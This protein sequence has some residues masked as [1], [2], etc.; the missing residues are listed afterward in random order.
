[1]YGDVV[2]N[3]HV[4]CM[5]GWHVPSTFRFRLQLFQD[6][7]D[8]SMSFSSTCSLSPIC[9][10]LAGRRFCPDSLQWV[11]PLP[12]QYYMY[13]ICIS[14]VSWIIMGQYGTDW[15][16]IGMD[17]TY[18]GPWLSSRQGLLEGSKI[19]WKPWVWR[20]LMEKSRDTLSQEIAKAHILTWGY[21]PLR[22]SHPLC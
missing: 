4:W 19:V 8:G 5:R 6:D 18:K 3:A 20:L 7:L 10:H 12:K 13:F 11:K 2:S 22:A 1:M 21:E 17:N 9:K 16:S 14:Y 15:K